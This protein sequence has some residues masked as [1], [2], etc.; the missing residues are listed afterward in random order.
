MTSATSQGP[1]LSVLVLTRNRL[2]ALRDCI[3]SILG[4]SLA[5]FEVVVLDDA[6]DGTDTAAAV[7]REFGDERVRAFRVPEQLGVSGG[8]NSLMQ[9]A[10]GEV[11][12][13]ID[14]DAVFTK[15]DALAKVE[16]CFAQDD[17]VG[18]VA[19]HVTNV[20]NA[21][22]T[23]TVPFSR[24]AIARDPQIIARRAA[25][26]SFR[27][28][29]HAIRKRVVDRLGGYRSDMFFGEEEL[30]LAYRIIQAG[31]RIVYEPEIEVE[32]FPMP[33]QV[34]RANGQTSVE[35]Y[36][37]VRNRAYLAYR[38]LPWRYA[39]PYLAVWMAHYSLRSIRG[40]G[41]WNL[42]RGVWATPSYL[43]GVTREV[44]DRNA[45]AYLTRHG[46]RLWY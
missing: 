8:R 35:L 15:D 32:H 44:L 38:Y 30:D 13:S 37:H 26:S 5:D 14:D 39:I 22:R 46:G 42:V 29:G 9:Q 21:T 28:C 4:Q 27:G 1:Q 40:D 10:R 33:S 12:V 34:G 36:Y 25:V 23:P 6:S 7:K 19:F 3:R 2:E 24:A 18:A 45:L 20:V 16:D 43:R 17:S 31:A 11:L 41:V